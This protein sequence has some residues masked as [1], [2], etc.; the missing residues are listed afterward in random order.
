[1]KIAKAA[2]ATV[3][4]EWTF[5]VQPCALMFSGQVKHV[6]L[7]ISKGHKMMLR[8]PAVV[9]EIHSCGTCQQEGIMPA[10]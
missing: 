6:A 1:M 10:S 2:G 7:V 9:V 8:P 3:Q 5:Y 4:F